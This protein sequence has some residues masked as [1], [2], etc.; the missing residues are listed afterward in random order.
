[1][2]YKRHQLKE[3]RKLWCKPMSKTTL[4]S[5][6]SIEKIVLDL[7]NRSFMPICNK[8][9]FYFLARE[10]TRTAMENFCFMQY[11][12]NEFLLRQCT[13]KH[14]F[15]RICQSRGKG[16]KSKWSFIAPS[17]ASKSDLQFPRWTSTSSCPQTSGRQFCCVIYYYVIEYERHQAMV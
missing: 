5:R 12:K 9:W 7:R 15:L 2:Y 17:I 13:R 11:G 8:L 4:H 16:A 3:Q 6:R 14:F 1:M 10:K